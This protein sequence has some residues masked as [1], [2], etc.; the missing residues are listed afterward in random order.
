L[1]KAACWKCPNRRPEIPHFWC[2]LDERRSNC[3][4]GRAAIYQQRLLNCGNNCG[5]WS[6]A[7]SEEAARGEPDPVLWPKAGEIR[8]S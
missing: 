2:A 5:P 7:I 3:V 8:S 4:S 6:A 1:L